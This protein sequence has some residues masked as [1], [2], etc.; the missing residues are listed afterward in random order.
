MSLTRP[1]WAISALGFLALLG[2]SLFNLRQYNT[3]Y[4][5]PKI[6]S[7]FFP[8]E[9][10]IST[11]VGERGASSFEDF[12]EQRKW[13][14]VLIFRTTDCYSCIRYASNLANKLN[15]AQI[16]R[17][18]L[19]ALAI[20]TNRKELQRYLEHGNMIQPVFLL[21]PILENK[22]FHKYIRKIGKTP[23]LVLMEG[24]NVQYATRLV[25]DSQVMKS[26]YDSIYKFIY[27]EE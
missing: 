13:T 17:L 22:L 10:T 3:H 16:D 8:V 11:N 7:D 26:R 9:K 27:T 19:A 25:P 5:D 2:I 6:P 15:V 21:S 12:I 1:Q 20:D 23:I 18:K 4:E 24:E 14:A